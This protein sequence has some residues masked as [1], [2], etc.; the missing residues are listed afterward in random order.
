MFQGASAGAHTRLDAAA[1][2]ARAW[3]STKGIHNE[4]AWTHAPAPTAWEPSLADRRRPSPSHASGPASRRRAGGR[5]GCGFARHPG[6]GDAGRRQV[7]AAG[8]G[9]PCPD[10][11]RDRRAGGLGGAP[12]QP[13]PASRGG[14]RRPPLAGAPRPPLGRARGGTGAAGPR[15]AARRRPRPGA[16]PALPRRAQ[17]LGA[18]RA[19]R[20]RAPCH[21]GRAGR[22]R[23]A[24][25]P[26]GSAPSC[27]RWSPWRWRTR[28]WTRP[29]SPWWRR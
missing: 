29:R 3:A 17:G 12:R 6:R 1:T 19:G 27:P 4:S 28:G 5:D 23:D 20:Q 13:A 24:P 10:R 22:A 8:A 21:L 25:P 14:V 18:A 11:G 15:Q 16:G 26:T 2:I 9:R 7:A